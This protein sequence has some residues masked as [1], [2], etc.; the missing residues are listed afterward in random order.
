[1]SSQAF[2]PASSSQRGT[3]SNSGESRS[4]NMTLT[5]TSQTKGT[6]FPDIECPTRL[7][8]VKNTF[9]NFDVGL[10]FALEGFFQVRRVRSESSLVEL[11]RAAE[12][13]ARPAL[14]LLAHHERDDESCPEGPSSSK[15]ASPRSKPGTACGPKG[16]EE[17]QSSSR[18]TSLGSS[19]HS[20]NCSK[21]AARL[22]EFDYPVPLVL[23]N[24]FI[25]AIVGLEDFFEE[26][27]VR[28]CPGSV[29]D[30][31]ERD[32]VLSPTR[33]APPPTLEASELP[34]A[35][36]AEHFWGTCRP[37]A[38]FT[39]VGCNNGAQCPRCHLCPPGELKRQQKA[40]R[41]AHRRAAATA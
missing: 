6:D 7:L 2:V 11:A 9:I 8:P 3:R 22:R 23:K 24:T 4:A 20:S 28:S 17:L 18:S 12:E 41:S 31:E 15:S 19:G 36:S 33:T 1:M 26:R 16:A 21:E 37:C 29:V 14:P 30:G 27:R 38:F 35:G 25:H 32:R 10:P 13:S 40:K 5:N 34:S 39:S